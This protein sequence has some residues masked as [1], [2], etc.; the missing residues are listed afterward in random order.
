[1]AEII[2]DQI[3]FKGNIVSP[4]GTKKVAIETSSPITT[5]FDLG[6][7]A[8]AEILQL[9]GQEIADSIRNGTK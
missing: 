9:G 3:I 7:N 1:L 6:I 5:G 4:D 2:N 8:A